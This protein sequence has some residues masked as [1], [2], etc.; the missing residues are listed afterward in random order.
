MSV[1]CPSNVAEVGVLKGLEPCV[2][3][4]MSAKAGSKLHEK[5]QMILANILREEDNKFCADCLAK[6]TQREWGWLESFQ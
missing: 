5:H 4:E 1:G 3:G 2:R 6:G